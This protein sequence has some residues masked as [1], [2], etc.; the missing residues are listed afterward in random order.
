M[1]ATAAEIREGIRA[2]LA[3]VFEPDVQVSAYRLDVPMRETLQI[4]GTDEVLY[5]QAMG[6]QIDNWTFQLQALAGSPVS[7]IAQETLDTWKSRGAAGVKAAIE[8]DPTLGGIVQTLRVERASSDQ[9]YVQP[10][11]PEMLGCLFTV[12]VINSR[13]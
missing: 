1:A 8:A 4:I 11:K 10:N 9:I 13:S 3:A 7:Q 6:G 12:F 5:D 2:S